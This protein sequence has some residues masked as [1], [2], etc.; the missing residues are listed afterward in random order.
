MNSNKNSFVE[1]VW[2][3]SINVRDFVSLNVKPYTGDHEFLCGPSEKTSKLWEQCKVA[4]KEERE[5]NGLRSVDTEIVSTI[6][7][8]PAGYID[9]ENEVI[10]GLQT[11]ELLKR[12]MKP[13]GGYKVVK[14]STFRAW[15]KTFGFS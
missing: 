14:K 10:V 1:G 7:S 13:Y 5:R 2:T 12:A 4:L 9:Q 8:F 6:N 15:L 11:D 3:K